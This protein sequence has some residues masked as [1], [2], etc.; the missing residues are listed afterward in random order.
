MSNSLDED[1][2]EQNIRMERNTCGHFSMDEKCFEKVS[3]KVHGGINILFR[4]SYLIGADR[5]P[6][7]IDFG[8][9]QLNKP[10]VGFVATLGFG[11]ENTAP[12]NR[13][14]IKK[15]KKLKTV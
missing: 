13:R 6:V 5:C 4:L 10:R 11:P 7:H 12:M 2:D 1:V 15:S 14:G 3:A 8:N 9:R